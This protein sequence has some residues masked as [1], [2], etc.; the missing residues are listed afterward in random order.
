MSQPL[1]KLEIKVIRQVLG[2]SLRITRQGGAEIS[3][4]SLGDYRKN[5][6]AYFFHKQPNGE[7]YIRRQI[8]GGYAPYGWGAWGQKYIYV[9]HRDPNKG[10]NGFGDV[11]EAA[12]W[13]KDY[14]RRRC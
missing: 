2:V 7:I 11:M 3:A 8:D 14:I 10:Y 6:I 4:T 9:I 1:T 5:S 12:Y 13:L